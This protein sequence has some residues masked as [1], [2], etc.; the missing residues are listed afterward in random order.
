M[1]EALNIFCSSGGG[2]KG[3]FQGGALE[4]LCEAGIELHGL[5]GV[6]TGS[7]Q[8]GFVAA[9]APG[10]GPQRS[11]VARLKEIWL[12]IS[13]SGSIYRKPRLGHLGVLLAVL[14]KRP[15]LYSF[16]PFQELLRQHLQ[17]PPRRPLR[18]GTVDLCSGR[19][20]AEEPTDA[21]TLRRAILASCSIPFFFPPVE[22]SLVDGGVRNI[23]P[24]ALAFDLAAEMLRSPTYAGRRVRLFLSLASPRTVADERRPWDRAGLLDVGLRALEILEAENYA[25]DVEGARRVNELVGIFDAHPELARPPF[26][27]NK[28]HA[29]LVMIEPDRAPFSS[30]AF[31]P[32]ALRA[33]WEHGRERARAALA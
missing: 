21:G 28:R 25:W 4:T 2:S 1:A 22:L 23:A 10:L 5:V 32:P 19:F 30:L 14:F 26:L 17:D 29:E 13:G 15:G 12:G 24:V 27:A 3:A 33:Y 7:I 11:Q 20:R 18:L 8:A 9:A 31:D 6:S 16:A